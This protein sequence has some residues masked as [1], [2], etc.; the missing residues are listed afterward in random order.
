MR[1]MVFVYAFLFLLCSQSSVIGSGFGSLNATKQTP[2]PDVR[3]P[4]ELN[5]SRLIQRSGNIVPTANNSRVS[6]EAG[7]PSMQNLAPSS[8]ADIKP[9][10]L[11]NGPLMYQNC[12]LS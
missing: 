11:E 3:K 2:T 7:P 1:V 9:Q 6:Q 12:K 10:R 4:E 8:S 5:K